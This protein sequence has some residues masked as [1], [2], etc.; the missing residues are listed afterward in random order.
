MENVTPI[1][2]KTGLHVL[3]RTGD[4]PLHAPGT[5]LDEQS[6]SITERDGEPLR[7][8]T[9]VLVE[10]G[11]GKYVIGVQYHT[12]WSNESDIDRAA[13]CDDATTVRKAIRAYSQGIA[14]MPI[15]FPAGD[16]FKDRQTNLVRELRRRFDELATKILDRAEFAETV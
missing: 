13:V 7:A 8:F 15:G 6:V 11:S 16:R 2:G 5:I 12:T 14:S 10:C 4:A 9:V 3:K 1:V